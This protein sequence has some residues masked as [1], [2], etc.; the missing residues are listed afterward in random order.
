MNIFRGGESEERFRLVAPTVSSSSNSLWCRSDIVA[1]NYALSQTDHML[2]ACEG[3][4][5][6]GPEQCPCYTLLQNKETAINP[7]V[8]SSSAVNLSLFVHCACN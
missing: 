5:F 3:A 1:Q 4:G 7:K 8:S 6:R 2:D